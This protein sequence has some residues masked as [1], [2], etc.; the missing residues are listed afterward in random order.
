MIK[1]R[2]YLTELWTGR[3]TAPLSPLLFF[4]FLCSVLYAAGLR[5][6]T[7]L[8]QAGVFKV[9]RLGRPVIS[10]GNL[11]VGG[12]GKTPAAI[13]LASFFKSRGFRPA[14]LS[15][16][17]AGRSGRPVTVVSDGKRRLAGPEEAGDEPC[18]M[19]ESLRDVPVL[20][21]HRR[22]LSGKYA[23]DH[24]KTDIL[25]LDDAFQHRGLA[26]DFDIVLL[27]AGAPFGNG[28]LIPRGPLREPKE[29]LKR[30]DAIVLTGEAGD[31]AEAAGWLHRL[32]A[33]CPQA[34]VLRGVYQPHGLTRNGCE[35]FPSDFLRGKR[36]V[37]FCGI[38]N[39]ESFRLSLESAGARIVSFISF[40]DHFRYSE[41]DTQSICRR[42]ESS[43]AEMIV[44]TEKDGIKLAG[45]PDFYQ[46][47]FLLRI[48][49][50]ILPEG[51]LERMIE[52]RIKR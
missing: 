20:T 26:R 7:V 48:R 31:A 17:Y 35:V 45:H 10:I 2:E 36:V 25:I 52:K 4:L 41:A 1:P 6:R 42:A 33:L 46:R 28:F 8:F 24:L 9:R 40:P 13:S 11:T 16:G 37:A 34:P 43:G 15:R 29:V 23:I 47:I 12:T 3:K 18:M 49:L 44:T 51:E 50:E 38:G 32:R 19:A 22:F 39:P 14:V 5:I 27:N 21:G 30:A